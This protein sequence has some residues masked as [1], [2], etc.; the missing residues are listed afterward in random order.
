MIDIVKTKSRQLPYRSSAARNSRP[1]L[2]G[3]RPL[4]GMGAP[5]SGFA[6]VSEDLI[7]NARNGLRPSTGYRRY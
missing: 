2:P 7:K 4:P 1:P 6:G 5:S 3:A